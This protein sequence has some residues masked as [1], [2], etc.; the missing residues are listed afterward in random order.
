SY[1]SQGTYSSRLTSPAAPSYAWTLNETSGT[2]ATASYG[3]AGSNG[4]YSVSG[5]TLNQPGAPTGITDASVTLSGGQIQIPTSTIAGSGK[6]FT[7]WFKTTSNG[8]LL[9]KNS[10]AVGAGSSSSHNPVLYVDNN[11]YL[12]A[13]DYSVFNSSNKTPQPVNDG[14]W[15]HVVFAVSATDQTLYVDGAKVGTVS[16]AVDDT[17]WPFNY[18]YIGNG[19]TGGWADAASG[20]MPFQGSIDE[21]AIYSTVFTDA[22]V[23]SQDAPAPASNI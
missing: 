14:L 4:T 9:S 17:G 3:G 20:W 18:A 7:M 5:V 11:G 19:W 22:D 10:V 2:T 15:H 21:V 16:G 6:T 23:A 13:N 1:G 12:R 8:V